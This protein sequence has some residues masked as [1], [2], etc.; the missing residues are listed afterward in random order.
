LKCPADLAVAVL[1]QPKDR[2]DVTGSSSRGGSWAGGQCGCWWIRSLRTDL[3]LL[4]GVPVP[5]ATVGPG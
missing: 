5:G 3:Q 2:P 1:G 4:E